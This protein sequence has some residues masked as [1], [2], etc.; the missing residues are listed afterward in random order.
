MD[1]VTSGPDPETD[2]IL[3]VK[4]AYMANYQIQWQ[5]STV[6]KPE[7][8]VSPAVLQKV[9]IEEEELLGGMPLEELIRGL[10]DLQYPYAPFLLF[11]QDS[12]AGF[13]ALLNWTC[14]SS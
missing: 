12:T 4:L 14:S 1:L 10:N 6:V 3:E 2:Q 7:T 9:S 8:P 13:I 11:E 5:W